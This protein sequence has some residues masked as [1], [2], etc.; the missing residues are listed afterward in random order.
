MRR[1]LLTAAILV[2]SAAPALAVP[3]KVPFAGTYTT[4]IAGKRP[5]ALNGLWTIAIAPGGRYGIYK[6]GRK[7]VLGSVR[8]T[9]SRAT[10]VDQA[11]PAACPSTRTVGIYRWERVGAK[12]RLTPLSD[13]CR[14]RRIVLSTHPLLRL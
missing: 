14:G 1:L 12:L 11:G 4:L 13:S 9:G 6:G 2:A 3:A 5:T 10:F 8:T 7:L